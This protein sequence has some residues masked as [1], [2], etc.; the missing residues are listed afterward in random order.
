LIENDNRNVHLV[1]ELAEEQRGRTVVLL[2]GAGFSLI[3]EEF[4]HSLSP[5]H[6]NFKENICLSI[7][8]RKANKSSKPLHLRLNTHLTKTK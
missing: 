4:V 2:L 7:L 6:N 1:T 3:Q 5:A 8:L